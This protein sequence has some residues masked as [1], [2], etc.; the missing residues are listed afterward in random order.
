[1]DTDVAD[2]RTETRPRVP[3]RREPALS[4]TQSFGAE[5]LADGRASFRLWAPAEPRVNLVLEDGTLMPLEAKDGGWHETVTD[6][7]KAGTRYAFEIAGGRRVPDPASRHQPDDVHGFSELIDPNA[8]A[9]S[10]ADWRGRPWH[11]TVLYEMHVGTFTPEGTFRDAIDRLDHLVDLG[12]TAVELLPVADFPGRRNWGYDGA[13]LYAPDAAYGRPDDLRALVDAAH[14]KGL[15]VFLDVVYNHFGP[16]GNYFGNYAPSLYTERHHTPWGAAINYDGEDSRPVRDFVIENALY[17]MREFHIDGFRFDA[18]HA[19]VDDS[20]TH[21]L[22]ELAERVRSAAGSRRHVHLVVENDANQAHLL[23]RTQDGRPRWYDAQ[24]TDD[25]HHGL[26]VAV[27]GESAGYYAP[28]A[29]RIDLLGRALA[30]GFAYQGEVAS[31]NNEPRG[32]PSSHL[33]PAAFVSFLQNHDQTGN[34]A[35]G[36]RISLLAGREAVRAAACLYLLAPQ[37]P[38]LF[39]GEE[40]AASTPFPFFCDYE[41]DLAKAVRNG[42]REEFSHFP[43]FQ[44]PGL[45]ETIPD[46]I[47]EATFRATKLRWQERSEA[48][49]A[50]WLDWYRRALAVRRAEIVPLVPRIGGD[51]GRFETIGRSGLTVEWRAADGRRLAVA[52]NLSDEEIEA[53]LPQGREIWREGAK[54]DEGRL[55][56]WQVVW[57]L[58]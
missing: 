57:T 23:E 41:G 3:A 15:T 51:A 42:R 28:F 6:L 44:D 31:F 16:E 45:I 32:T 53:V 34:R 38:M 49:H 14:A 36:E 24:W 2:I 29:G 8:Y 37:I 17:W 7:V 11:E 5:V 55:G 50:D 4:R 56:P 12:V 46:P 54:R 27:T 43:E 30:E 33:P 58:A 10:D 21:I 35:F 20:G 1:L 13:L 19:I 26:H 40:W 39:M 52:A 48:E 18:V 25:L 9:W 22:K 47:A